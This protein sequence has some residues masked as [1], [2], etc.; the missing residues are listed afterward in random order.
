[1]RI[2]TLLMQLDTS[3]MDSARCVLRLS[4]KV[5]AA[6]SVVSN[7]IKVTP[8]PADLVALWSAIAFAG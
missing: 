2:H 3:G 6:Q 7:T 1:M 8:R 5:S 4:P